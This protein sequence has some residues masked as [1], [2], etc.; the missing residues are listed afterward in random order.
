MK[1]DRILALFLFA[2]NLGLAWLI[3]YQ[4]R[5]IETQRILIRILWHDCR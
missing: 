5:V 4:G 3:S 2:V 1:L